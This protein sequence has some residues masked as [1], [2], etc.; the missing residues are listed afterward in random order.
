MKPTVFNQLQLCIWNS[1]I[2]ILSEGSENKEWELVCFPPPNATLMLGKVT[3][4][5]CGTNREVYWQIGEKK[6]HLKAGGQ[7]LKLY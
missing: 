7:I 1:Y 3:Q 6:V 4:L 5:F 2:I